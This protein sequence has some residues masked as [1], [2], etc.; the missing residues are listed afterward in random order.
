[1][2]SNS[3]T[4]FMPTVQLI[5]LPITHNI[6]FFT[7]LLPEIVNGTR[8]N[9][10]SK[11]QPIQMPLAGRN[12]ES[13]HVCNEKSHRIAFIRNK[14]H[15]SLPTIF[16]NFKLRNSCRYLHATNRVKQQVKHRRSTSTA[17]LSMT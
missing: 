8:S 13:C 4:F 9:R 14:H 15:D 16:P 11:L 17:H 10:N 6:S 7:F 1:M 5:F 12:T 2:F 3:F